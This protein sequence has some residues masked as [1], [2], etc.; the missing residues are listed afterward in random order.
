MADYSIKIQNH[1]GDVQ[2]YML[3][4][5]APKAQGIPANQVFTNVYQAAPSIQS[6]HNSHALFKMHKTFYAVCGTNPDPLAIDH[7][8][9]TSA[10]ESVN[11][12]EG[13]IPGSKVFLTAPGNNPEWD[14]SRAS[15]T[16]SANGFSIM[17]DTNFQYP[18]ENNIFCGLG[19][20]SPNDDTDILPTATFM[21]HP[22]EQYTIW[23]KVLY[24]VTTGTFTPGTVIDVQAVGQV[25]PVDFE[26]GLPDRTFIHTAN[27]TFVPQ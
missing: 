18:N 3:F 26:T 7:S 12:T 24:Y 17:T 23:P 4:Q 16:T 22:G 1:S 20:K 8:V 25:L 11:L 13:D 27:G 19:A 9:T 14:D 2:S 5:E 21:A 15:T 6:G 10:A